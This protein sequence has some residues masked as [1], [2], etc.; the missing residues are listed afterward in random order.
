MEER[1]GIATDIYITTI[2]YFLKWQA[3]NTGKIFPGYS[4]ISQQVVVSQFF[5]STS[6]FYHNVPGGDVITGHVRIFLH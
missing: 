5:N 4:Q 6:Q 3:D 2:C 1:K